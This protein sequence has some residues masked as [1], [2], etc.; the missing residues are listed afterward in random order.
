MSVEP[1]GKV[2][3]LTLFRTVDKLSQG[4]TEGI[5]RTM[6]DLPGD[7]NREL[8]VKNVAQSLIGKLSNSL[9]VGV[10]RPL[11]DA[12][13]KS[14][15][16]LNSKLAS[17][18][19]F[20]IIAKC[21]DSCRP[22]EH[23]ELSRPSPSVSA[24][25][26][27]LGHSDSCEDVHSTLEP[28][29]EQSVGMI[30]RCCLCLTP[31][32]EEELI[33][34]NCCNKLVGSICW[35]ERLEEID[36]CCFCQAYQ[37]KSDPRLLASSEDTTDYKYHFISKSLQDETDTKADVETARASFFEQG[38]SFS[39][40]SAGADVSLN[41][42]NASEALRASIT[43]NKK[44][45]V[46]DT[47]DLS[48]DIKKMRMADDKR[49][50]SYYDTPVSLQS[51]KNFSRNFKLRTAM[52]E[53]PTAVLSQIAAS[54]QSCEPVENAQH[55]R[56]NPSAL[57]TTTVS[58]PTKLQASLGLTEHN[59]QSKEGDDHH[60]TKS[61]RLTLIDQDVMHHLEGVRRGDLLDLVHS[62][63]IERLRRTVCKQFFHQAKF[64][65]NGNIDVSICLKC[66]QE[67]DLMH[68][69]KDWPRA[70]ES[71]VLTTQLQSYK[72]TVDHIQIGTMKISQGFEKSTT[73]QKLSRD[74]TP[75]LKSLT[76]PAD[77]RGVC[78]NKKII[79]LNPNESTSITITFRTAQ[80]ANEAIEHG[81][82]WNH[83]RRLC[84]RQGAH[85]RVTQCGH[86]QA[87][88]HNF[89]DCSS[90]PRC[91]VCA[92]VHLSTA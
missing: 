91:R 61:H 9:F 28:S 26:Q 53:D 49:R 15:S 68:G 36:K 40:R 57:A 84:R 70:F 27:S 4:V 76:N 87:F 75:V 41:L 56:P 82:L 23:G 86:C 58:A 22:F 39:T 14:F 16:E 90:T 46:L 55:K 78:W 89:K 30:D 25:A 33:T 72:V 38:S 17:R 77:I 35:E 81:I 74:N 59:P 45:V 80:Q 69:M 12:L 34:T 62:A 43:V 51:L 7:T 32:S 65:P 73:V 6:E 24:P 44:P 52:P 66:S 29:E 2:L 20:D 10:P 19:E 3:Q 60:A 48:A 71:F 13:H 47:S 8:E 50:R 5:S 11:F 79:G 42:P 67:S 63:L 83:E 21:N 54:Q 92:G 1:S 64:L 31:A 88:G 85:P 37:P 18:V